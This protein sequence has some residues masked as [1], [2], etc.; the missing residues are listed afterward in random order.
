MNQ[1]LLMSILQATITSGTAILIA[2]CG[3]VLT[4]R[5]GV[6]NLGIEGMM[7]MGCVAG[8]GAAAVTG[9]PW[10]GLLAALIIGAL[11]GFLYA[12]VVIE[13]KANQ[14]VTGLAFVML[15]T[16][17]SGFLGR[18][19]VGRPLA[20]TF[21]PVKVP[22][23][24][25]IPIL[26]QA[27]FNQDLLVY[28]S[29][30]MV[31]ALWWFIFRS[32][33]GLHLRAVGENP[34]AA[35]AAGI[36]VGAERYLYTVLGGALIGAAGAYLSLA[37]SPAWLENMTGGR[38]WIAVALVVFSGWNPF[39]AI[40]GAYLFGG[41]DA[42]TLRLQAAG[43]GISPFALNALPYILTVLVLILSASGKRR[44]VGPAALGQA[45]DRETR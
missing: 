33:P 7:L 37:Y 43:A 28:L 14:A 8:F 20:Q 17:L 9:I 19:F 29:L 10:A 24:G 44:I 22:L 30:L 38:G 12:I 36:R 35:D 39:G 18:A 4:A 34:A 21:T 40:V 26:G 15:G 5:A 45:Y 27:V 1:A 31:P 3:G 6:L 32:R 23:L 42:I 41:V 11:M 25:D 2:T 13:F 16:G